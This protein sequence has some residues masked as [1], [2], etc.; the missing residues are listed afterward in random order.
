MSGV[1]AGVGVGFPLMSGWERPEMPL[2]SLQCPAHRP[3][4][5]SHPTA[6]N[7][8]ARKL[9]EPRVPLSCDLTLPEVFLFA[10]GEGP[11]FQQCGQNLD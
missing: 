11:V 9:A 3:R 1:S 8:P 7:H 5:P 10:C 2:N 4:P 6:G